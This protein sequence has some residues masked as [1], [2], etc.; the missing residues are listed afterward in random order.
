MGGCANVIVSPEMQQ[1]QAIADIRRKRRKPPFGGFP[2]G[3]KT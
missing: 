2:Y 1:P 3:F